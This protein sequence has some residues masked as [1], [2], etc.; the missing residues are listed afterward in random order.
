MDLPQFLVKRFQEPSFGM[1]IALTCPRAPVKP[2][3]WV[4]YAGT[5][6]AFRCSLAIYASG[7]VPGSGFGRIAVGGAR[8]QQR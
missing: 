5:P 4:E 6:H 7:L 1:H 8:K 3:V 2:L